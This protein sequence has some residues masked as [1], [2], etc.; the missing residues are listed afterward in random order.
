MYAVIK[1]G[2]KQQKVTAGDV[3]E[4]EKLV[5]EGQT[6]TF[7]PILVVDDDGAH[8]RGRRGR[9]GHGDGRRPWA[10]RRA[11]RSRSSSTGP[12]PATPKRGGHRQLLT[13]L[14]ITDVQA[15]RAAPR[16][17][18]RSARPRPG[19][20]GARGAPEAVAAEAPSRLAPAFATLDD[21]WHTR[22]AAA[23]PATAAIPTAKRLGVKA[24][25][26]RDRHAR[27]PSS[28]V[29]A[30]P[31]STRARAWAKGSDDTLF[32]L[33]DGRISLPRV[34]RTQDRHGRRGRRSP[35]QAE[36]SLAD[37]RVHL[38]GPP[39]D[40][41]LLADPGGLQVLGVRALRLALAGAPDHRE[42][43]GGPGHDPLVGVSARGGM[44]R[45]RL[46]EVEGGALTIAVQ[47]PL[48]QSTGEPRR[49]FAR[50][51]DVNERRAG[52]PSP[53]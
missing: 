39:L 10:R 50:R 32:A 19:E 38:V 45:R 6:I 23:R 31:A 40:Q 47:V 22:R 27:A 7:H 41:V 16:P 11:R 51:I 42:R 44:Q 35:I 21:L 15:R 20:A 26:G 12:S 18:P 25:G 13:L 28:C 4:V 49:R 5:H 53:R 24:F 36:P 17:R 9:E 43:A 1:T 14:E 29:S 48:H 52:V 2:G 8:A 46:R 33:R 3:I 37:P 34:S 30:A